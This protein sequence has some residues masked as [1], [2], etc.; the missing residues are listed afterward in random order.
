MDTMNNNVV[1]WYKNRVVVTYYTPYETSVSIDEV[2]AHIP[3]YHAQINKILQGTP[4]ELQPVG[5]STALQSISMSSPDASGIYIFPINEPGST[6]VDGIHFNSIHVVAAFY[7]VAHKDA[8]G[9]HTMSSMPQQSASGGMNMS[10]TVDHTLTIIEHLHK[11]DKAGDVP[12]DAMPHWFWTGTDGIT[13]GCPISPPIPVPDKGVPG[14]W[15]M[16]FAELADASLQ[17]KTGEGVTVFVLDTLPDSGQLRS[18]TGRG[19][20]N[21]LL[22]NMMTNM[23][24]HTSPNVEGMVQ[25]P[26]PAINTYYFNVPGPQETA[27]TGKDIYGRL[28]GFPMADH[29]LTIAGMIRDLAPQASIECV[30]VL[31]DYGV[32]DTDTLYKALGYIEGRVANDLRGKPAIVNMSLVVVPPR[33]E[34]GRLGLDKHSESASLKR[35]LRGLAARMA[36]MAQRGVVFTASAGNDSDPRDFLMN[37]NEV[38]FGPR[39]PA[40]FLYPEKDVFDNPLVQTMLPVGAVCHAEDGNEI[41]AAVYSNSP[42]PQGFGAFGGRLPKP[43]PWMP[44][45]MSHVPA[46]VDPSERVDAVCGVYSASLYPALS[47]NDRNMPASKQMPEGS[48]SDYP[49]HDAPTAQSTWAYWSG[50]SFAAPIISSLAARIMQPTSEGAQPGIDVRKA[51]QSATSQQITWTGLESGGDMSGPVVMVTQTWTADSGE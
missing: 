4:Y 51:I 15:K 3:D 46:Q 16:D 24:D 48:P 26:P 17:G 36:S 35:I 42:G 30:R 14:Q 7:S 2:V 13:H 9:E 43:L 31:N 34:W 22:Q 33:T 28:V 5:G 40:A 21:R 29:G 38:R 44:S 37:P 23:I 18:A 41:E 25:A 10:Q 19:T 50:T 1:Y 6:I 8:R 45:A 39:F 27:R 20:N 12:F 47:K 32:G 11:H 49:M